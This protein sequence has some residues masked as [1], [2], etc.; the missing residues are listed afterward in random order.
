[1]VIEDSPSLAQTYA[2]ILEGAGHS[3]VVVENGAE[4]DSAIASMPKPFDAIL[5]DLQLPDYDGLDWL[6]QRP[7]L[8]QESAVVVV[9][10]D[11][12]IN[13]AIS[14][15]RLGAYDFL[16]KP[17]APPRLLTTARNALE[18]QKL[19]EKA[20]VISR[21][22][23]RESFQG[24]IGK[25]T[26]MQAV[27]SAIENVATSKATVFITGESGTGKE[28]AAEA[29][30]QTGPRARKRFVAINCGAIPENLLESELF[31][32]VKGSFTGAIADRKGAAREAD[33]GTLFLD[34]ICEMDLSLQVKLLRF[35][36]SGMVQPVGSSRPEPV[37]VRVICATNRDPSREVAEGRFRED[38][39]YRLAVIPLELPP[40]RDRPGDVSLIAQS[41]LER[42]GEEEA[43]HFEPLSAQVSAALEQRQWP[44]NVRELQNLIRRAVVMSA[45]PV[46]G[47]DDL[48]LERTHPAPARAADPAPAAFMADPAA[49]ASPDFAQSGPTT[50]ADI[51]RLA[52]E[53]AIH[54]AGGSIPKAA[55]EL[56]VSASTIYRMKSRWQSA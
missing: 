40:L 38:L 20:E 17:I 23:G 25:S 27:Y 44:G 18:R 53:A 46:I 51:E 33:G 37:N 24:F 12:S 39:F 28:V 35:L 11:G 29:I 9:T 13:R 22:V 2:G 26:P 43:K 16:V 19:Y 56:G 50:L 54:R 15:M 45:G 41:F 32:H 55:G 30:H 10:A 36:Q 5:L 6:E 1:M 14:A 34:E 52:V 49:T 47:L 4:A 42:F 21:I 48:P 7:Q 8:A 3:V 31:G